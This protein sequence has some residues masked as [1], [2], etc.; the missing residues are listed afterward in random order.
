MSNNENVES[1]LSPIT[2]LLHN[3]VQPLGQLANVAEKI[4]DG[5]VAVKGMELNAETQQFMG[6]LALAG[7]IVESGFGVWKEYVSLANTREQTA[8]VVEANKPRLEEIKADLEK[9]K[10]HHAEFT[11]KTVDIR[12]MLKLTKERIE[13]WGKLLDYV[14]SVNPDLMLMADNTIFDRAEKAQGH[15]EALLISLHRFMETR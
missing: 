14:V 1:R 4:I 2:D 5:K 10:L 6:K 8:Q 15:I 12:E 13:P 3:S 9:A 11:E 7:Q